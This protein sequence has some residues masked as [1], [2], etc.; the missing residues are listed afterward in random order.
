MR[1]RLIS[2]SFTTILFILI[3]N[4]ELSAQLCSCAA[5]PKVQISDRGIQKVGLA[6][7]SLFYDYHEIGHLYNESELLTKN[8]IQRT[9]QNI[10]V[11]LGYSFTSN[12]NA[13]VSWNFIQQ[14]LITTEEKQ[15]SGP[16]DITAMIKYRIH[17]PNFNNQF[18][19][20]AGI[21]LGIP[22]G[23][24]DLKQNQILL[25]PD[26]QPGSGVWSTILWGYYHQTYLPHTKLN[27]LSTFLIQFNGSYE[28]FS[29]SSLKYHPGNQ[30]FSSITAAYQ[31]ENGLQVSLSGRYRLSTPHK[32]GNNRIFASGGHYLLADSGLTYSLSPDLTISING[33]IPVWQ[34]VNGTQPATSWGV[35]T[36]FN[37]VLAL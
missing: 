36:G 15:T 37:Y 10:Q 4:S 6:S 21:G 20:S 16:G 11:E 24:T 5:P 31:L 28:R 1:F 29:G 35:T 23:R 30:L 13:S 9:A 14:S 12:L 32:S 26:L 27:L 25:Q 7:L 18:D 19:I 3:F 34:K 22:T 17:E 8:D 33:R 2:L